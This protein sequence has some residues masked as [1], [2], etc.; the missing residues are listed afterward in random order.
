MQSRLDMVCCPE[1]NRPNPRRSLLEQLSKLL[2]GDAEKQS[3]MHC[4][5]GLSSGMGL[6][7]IL[8]CCL[9]MLMMVEMRMVTATS[10]YPDPKADL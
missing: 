5:Q 10:K 1:C 7:L 9:L 2:L 4:L 8:V 3:A 6:L